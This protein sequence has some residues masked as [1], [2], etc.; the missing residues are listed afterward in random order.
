MRCA[1]TT[2]ARCLPRWC[3]RTSLR[4]WANRTRAAA[5]RRH[6]LRPHG[7]DAPAAVPRDLP[8]RHE[9]W[10]FPAPRPGRRAQSPHCRAGH[11][12]PPAWRPFNPRGRPV[13]VSAVVRLCAGGVLPELSRRRCARCQRARTV[14]AG[15]RTAGQRC[16]VP[17]RPA[18]DRH[19]GGAAPVAALRRRRLRC[20]GRSRRRPAPFQLSPPM[21]TVGGQPGRPA[22]AARAVG[23]RCVAGRR[24]RSAGQ[25]LDRRPAP[26]VFRPGRAVPAPSS[27]HAVARPGQRRQRPGA[28]AGAHA[29]AGP[30][31]PAAACVRRRTG[32]RHRPALRAPA[33]ACAAAVRA[34]GATPAR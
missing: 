12:A 28:A 2:L 30:I 23:G 29:R 11:R 13:P 26:P 4:C 15:Q 20:A 16:A 25:R 24:Q 18:G 33:R 10:R 32:R 21:A 34:A 8:A 1:P 17:C 22:P 5:H 6:Q 27:G 9:R 3:A 7:A 31:R 14:G 19:A